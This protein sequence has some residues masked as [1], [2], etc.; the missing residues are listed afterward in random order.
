MTIDL[1]KYR[2]RLL[3]KEQELLRE[4][5][6]IES[7]A[8]ESRSADVEDPIDEAISSEAKAAAFHESTLNMQTLQQVRNALRRM[9]EG[10]YG[11]CIDCGKPIEPARLEAVPWTP[12]CL[13]DQ[14]RHD[15]SE[16][17]P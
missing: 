1:Q 12:Y 8:R 14:Q 5:A 3:A 6:R 4:M 15:Q 10:D 11:T 7:E 2:E 16:Q 9:E 13:T 17:Q